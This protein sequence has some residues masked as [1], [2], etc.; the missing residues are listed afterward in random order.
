MNQLV[1]EIESSAFQELSISAKHAATVAQFPGIHRDPFDRILVAR[2]LG[3][4]LRF[5]TAD[6]NFS[7]YSKLV[8][9]IYAVRL[10]IG[11]LSR[12]NCW[13]GLRVAGMRSTEYTF[14]AFLVVARSVTTGF[15]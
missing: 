4:S 8:E 9:V 11:A 3:E 10:V 7:G 6:S 12:F 1:A 13:T 15:P 2:V 5:L 14:D